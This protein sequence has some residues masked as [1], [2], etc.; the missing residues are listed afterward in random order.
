MLNWDDV[1]YYIHGRLSLPSSFIEKSD[2]ELKKWIILTALREFS[3]YVPDLEYNY[4]DPTKAINQTE[5]RNEFKFYDEEEL[6]ILGIKEYYHDASGDFATGHP[7]LGPMSFSAIKEFALAAFKANLL[8]PIS[9]WGFTG[10]FIRP[11]KVRILPE[12]TQPFLIEYEREQPPDLRRIPAEHARAF[13]ELALSETMLWIGSIRSHYGDG[14]ITTPYGDI[15]LNGDTLKSDGDTLKRETVDRLR[16]VS[17]PSV[18]V[19]V[20]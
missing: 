19:V 7:V 14:R 3:D 6:P 20:H 10:K 1:L 2:E 9:F 15:P 13:M 5:R 16:E 17:M 4:V 8:K 11:N 12:C 18:F